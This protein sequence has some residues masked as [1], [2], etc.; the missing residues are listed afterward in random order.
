MA[1]GTEATG[2]HLGGG[3]SRAGQVWPRPG[4]GTGRVGSPV[5]VQEKRE[6]G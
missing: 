6:A 1:Q 2:I 5:Q 3:R 4:L